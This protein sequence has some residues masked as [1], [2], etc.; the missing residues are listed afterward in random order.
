MVFLV[1]S[2]YAL[3]VVISSCLFDSSIF[4]LT[5]ALLSAFLAQRTA[6]VNAA[7]LSYHYSCACSNANGATRMATP[8][9]ALAV[10]QCRGAVLQCRPHGMSGNAA[11]CV[12]CEAERRRIRIRIR[13]MIRMSYLCLEVIC[14]VFFLVLR[15]RYLYHH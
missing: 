1:N 10:R 13:M 11:K 6:S 15:M 12:S 7:L 14:G 5:A 2:T 8:G 3:L 4:M 9:P